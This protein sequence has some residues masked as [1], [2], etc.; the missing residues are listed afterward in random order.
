MTN[1]KKILVPTDLSEYARHAL[2]YASELASTHGAVLHL[3]YVVD[4]EW[5]VTY[6]G[7]ALSYHEGTILDRIKEEGEKGLQQLRRE[8]KGIEIETT[9]VIGSPH[10]EIV[11]FSRENDID[12]I[13]I[14]T[15]GRT[16]LSHVLLGSV[17]E[18]VVQMAPCPV[19]IVKHPEH[20]FVL[21]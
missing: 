21:P 20:E 13:V 10:V 14:A 19:L 9:V 8:I 2:T 4:T 17:A 16:G 5:L 3:L 6:G 11:R 18:R 12:L 7:V 1:I 15:H